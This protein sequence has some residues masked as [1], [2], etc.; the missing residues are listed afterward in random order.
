MPLTLLLVVGNGSYLT[1][2]RLKYC[3]VTSLYGPLLPGSADQSGID[4]SSIPRSNSDVKIGSLTQKPVLRKR[5][6][7]EV[8]LQQPVNCSS[9]LKK[10]TSAVQAEQWKDTE[11]PLFMLA[12]SQDHWPSRASWPYHPSLP[13]HR[14]SEEQ[15]NGT[16]PPSPR[17]TSALKPAALDDIRK[18]HVHFNEHVQQCIAL[19]L[20][21]DYESDAFINDCRPSREEGNR[22]VPP[23]PRPTSAL[24][25][26]APGNIRKKQVHFNE[27]VQQCIAPELPSDYES[28]VFASDY[29]DDTLEDDGIIIKPSTNRRLPHTPKLKKSDAPL[30]AE[31]K[32]ISVLPSTTLNYVDGSSRPQN[33]IVMPK[34][35]NSVTPKPLTPM[36]NSGSWG[37]NSA[38][39]SSLKHSTRRVLMKTDEEDASDA[40][41]QL[42]DAVP[43]SR[44]NTLLGTKR[45][46][47][48]ET[49]DK[50]SIPSTGPFADARRIPYCMLKRHEGKWDHDHEGYDDGSTYYSCQVDNNSGKMQEATSRTSQIKEDILENDVVSI[51]MA[52]NL[53]PIAANHDDQ[54]LVT[55]VTPGTIQ[56]GESS[57][58]KDEIPIND[59]ADEDEEITDVYSSDSDETRSNY[60][61]YRDLCDVVTRD[62]V[63]SQVHVS[64]IQDQ[65]RQRLVDRV[66]QEF[67]LIF[68]REWSNGFK[69]CAGASPYSGSSGSAKNQTDSAASSSHG[70][71]KRL[72]DDG[73]GDPPDK[74]KDNNR[75][76]PQMRH[77][78]T[79]T[80]GSDLRYA[81]PF[82]KHD[83]QQYSI[84][85]HRVCALSHWETIA[86]V[87]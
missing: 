65:M 15:G 82:R 77:G 48:E 31:G 40:G 42:P 39:P 10:T 17:L 53:I 73:D 79:S 76:P 12:T 69:E 9:L 36:P 47:T 28:D 49:S 70:P 32:T 46:E 14:H 22:T 61:S 38:I 72:R 8:M 63:S 25:P 54:S 1:L 81:C 27:P 44:E 24:K 7:L 78:L 51:N 64:I 59:S 74:C 6:M 57:I 20:P 45:L 52:V 87:K 2:R 84:Y 50:L 41:S 80:S 60:G 67:W 83:S 3:D 18:K 13:S 30:T 16:V 43:R 33:P 34:Y 75:G 56:P 19:E 66:M 5:R 26:T 21:S 29:Y 37:R 23:S 71:Q 58:T 62:Q 4:S 11:S 68:D 35:L 86:R 85:S 55:L